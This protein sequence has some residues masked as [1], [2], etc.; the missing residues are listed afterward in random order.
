MSKMHPVP[1]RPR[2]EI[3]ISIIENVCDDVAA[4]SAILQKLAIAYG[5]Y[6]PGGTDTPLDQDF[7]RGVEDLMRDNR[8]DLSR[9]NAHINGR[10]DD[11]GGVK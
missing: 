5:V 10:D 11:E 3:D 4:R 2:P 8:R 6:D 1:S 9:L 7:W